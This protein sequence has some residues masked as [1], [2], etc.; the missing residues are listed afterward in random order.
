MRTRMFLVMEAIKE[1]RILVKYINTKAMMADGL[2]KSLE[3]AEFTL[4]RMEVLH[5][6]D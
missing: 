5:L 6:S 4:F 2:T 1:G 3:G